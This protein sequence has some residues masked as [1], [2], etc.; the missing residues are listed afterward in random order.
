MSSW[1]RLDESLPDDPL[2]FRASRILDISDP[3]LLF[4][5]LMRF[6]IWV[7]RY[8]DDGDLA[9]LEPAEI[10]RG[11]GWGGDPGKFVEVLVDVG[12][13]VS[14]GERLELRNWSEQQ[15]KRVEA[16]NRDR[17]RKQR[18]RE[19]AKDLEKS[20]EHG[21]DVPRTSQGRPKDVPRTSAC[22]NG[23]DETERT[24]GT[25]ERTTITIAASA[26]DADFEKF[27][28]AYPKKRGKEDTKKAWKETAK[29]RPPTAQIITKLKELVESRDWQKE[30]GRYILQPASWLRAGGWDDESAATLPRFDKHGWPVFPEGMPTTN[31]K[32]R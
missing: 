30:K 17:D 12:L 5:K 28:S 16:R 18:E 26:S 24:N 2:I 7:S 32:G 29:I 11:A 1:I 31:E 8:S 4:G 23:T 19:A 9:D 27:W 13:L 14:V 3:D 10:A 21:A 25:D 22:T 6:A 20:P 15:G